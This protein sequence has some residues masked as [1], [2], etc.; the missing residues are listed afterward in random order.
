MPPAQT[1]TL[2]IDMKP[3]AGT[4]NRFYA[5]L[6][7]VRVIHADGTA[8]AH[9]QDEVATT[10]VRL[11]V[12]VWGIADARYSLGID[13]PGTANDQKLTLSLS[14]GYHELELHI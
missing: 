13:L 3:E 6:D 11:K 5:F 8:A 14:G 12:R 4:I 10:P 2:T 9:Y 7:G 1:R